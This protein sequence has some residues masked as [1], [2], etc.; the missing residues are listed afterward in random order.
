MAEQALIQAVRVSAPQLQAHQE[1]RR[2]AI[3]R[4]LLQLEFRHDMRKSMRT[5][6]LLVALTLVI[7]RVIG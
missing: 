5:I 1:R 6:V 2:M 3:R 7:S 4:W